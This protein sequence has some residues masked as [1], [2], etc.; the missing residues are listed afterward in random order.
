MSALAPP[1]GVCNARSHAV[2]DWVHDHEGHGGRRRRRRTAH[3][4]AGLAR[5]RVPRATV[6]Q[7][8]VADLGDP[9]VELPVDAACRDSAK[10]TSAS[11]ATLSWWGGGIDDVLYSRCAHACR[12]ERV[13]PDQMLGGSVISCSKNH[14]A[15]AS[16]AAIRVDAVPARDHLA[17]RA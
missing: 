17:C 10:R 9:A 12:D 3:A 1:P 4:S 11:R 2:C 6:D 15:A 8:D 7:R 16:R 13:L 5:L 14:E